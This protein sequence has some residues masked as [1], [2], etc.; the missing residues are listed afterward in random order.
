[1]MIPLNNDAIRQLVDLVLRE[2]GLPMRLAGLCTPEGGH[3]RVELVL[4]WDDPG[5]GPG[6][7]ALNLPRRS[8][9]EFRRA[10]EDR[11]EAAAH[12]FHVPVLR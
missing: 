7:L 4:A 11:L 12:R 1:M 6:L 2:W 3:D 5:G 10:L 8:A 9:D